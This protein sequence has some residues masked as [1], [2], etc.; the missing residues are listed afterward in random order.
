MA[1]ERLFLKAALAAAALLAA[2]SWQPA[3]AQSGKG[4]SL[5]NETSYVIEA[6][7]G[8][9]EGGAIV[10]EGWKKLRPGSCTKAL[11][12]PLTPGVHFLYGRTSDAHRGGSRSWGGPHDLCIDPL[13]SFSV[14]TLDDCSIMGLDEKGFRPVLVEKSGAWSTSFTETNGYSLQ[15]A[16]AAG[17]QRLLDDAGVYTGK[18]DGLIGR[19][20]RASIAQF[21]NER[22]LPASTSDAALIDILEQVADDRARNVGMTLC[23]RT[24]KKIWSAIALRAGEGWESRGWWGLEAGGCARVIDTPLLQ[25][26]YYIYGEMEEMDGGVR[27]LSRASD[28]FCVARAKFAINGRDNCEQSAYRTALFT[29]TAPAEEERIVFE[30]FERDF[31]RS[32]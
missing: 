31:S 25:A 4:W 32:R 14:E 27:T 2:A 12:A 23:N 19:K 1:L 29:A 15:K 6:A 16:S 11:D 21:L 26:D 28:A 17:V 22:N 5:C 20:T 30:F 13:G 10:V 3:E 8:R 9:P 18:I 7:I 24:K